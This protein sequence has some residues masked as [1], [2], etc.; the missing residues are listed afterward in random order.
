[1]S[2]ILSLALLLTVAAFYGASAAAPL[3]QVDVFVASQGRYHTYRTPALIVTSNQRP[4][5]YSCLAVLPDK[6]F[7]CLYE[8]GRTNAYEKITFARFPLDW[9]APLR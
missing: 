5:A 2:K 3:Q 9:V 8:S 7:G 6:T 4:A 1:V